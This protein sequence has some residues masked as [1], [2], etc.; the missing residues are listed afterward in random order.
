[1]SV[2]PAI[3]AP[4]K[5]WGSADFARV[6]HLSDELA[7]SAAAV[8]WSEPM[9]RKVLMALSKTQ[10]DFKSATADEQLCQAQVLVLALDRLLSALELN[11]KKL[12]ETDKALDLLFEDV[13]D[14]TGFQA[15]QFTTHLTS[16]S[17][18]LA[19][20]GS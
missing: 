19:K 12:P 16:F 13:K 18:V 15:A 17:E 7:K 3:P 10:A 20:T 2:T 9:T 5:K 8:S 11:N 4:P 6:Q 1:V 14:P